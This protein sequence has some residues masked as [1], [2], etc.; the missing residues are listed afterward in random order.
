MNN[1]EIDQL[2]EEDAFHSDVELTDADV[3]RHTKSIK[4]R[5]LQKMAGKDMSTD[6]KEVAALMKVADSLDKTAL[7]NIRNN[8]DQDSNAAVSEALSLI[9]AMQRQVGNTDP[10]MVDINNPSALKPR[11]I[12]IDVPLVELDFVP[13][14]LS[15]ESM[16]L[17]Y[18]SF[19]TDFETNPPKS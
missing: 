14:E 11:E 16:D 3:L 6:P 15:H 12:S 10:F 8:I 4:L 19:V 7:T 1:Y 2:A 13:G 9:T 5:L 17:Q 18:D